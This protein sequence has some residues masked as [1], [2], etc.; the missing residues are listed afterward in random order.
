[1]TTRKLNKHEEKL[2]ILL[3]DIST[4]NPIREYRFDEPKEGEKQRRWRFD[5]AFPVQ[6]IAFEVE[7]GTWMGGRHVN[8]I[9]FSKDCEKY[10]KAVKLGWKVYRLVP[11]MI[12]KEYL[13]ELLLQ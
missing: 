2:F 3:R 8:P 13:E 6:K 1:M 5:C 7:G 11:S 10:N 12:T 4:I 9:G